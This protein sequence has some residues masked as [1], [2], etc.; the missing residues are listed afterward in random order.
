MQFQSDISKIIWNTLDS[1][2]NIT[3]VLLC[4]YYSLPNQTFFNYGI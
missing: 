3:T 4:N 2:I 1:Y